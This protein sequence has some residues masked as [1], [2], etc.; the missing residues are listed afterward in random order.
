MSGINRS[1]CLHNKPSQS[2]AQREKKDQHGQHTPREG[3]TGHNRRGFGILGHHAA[4]SASPRRGVEQ[5]SDDE[6]GEESHV[7]KVASAARQFKPCAKRWLVE[8]S[9]PAS[10]PVSSGG[11]GRGLPG[12][13]SFRFTVFSRRKAGPKKAVRSFRT[14]VHSLR[15]AAQD[16]PNT[17][18]WARSDFLTFPLSQEIP[19]P[20]LRGQFCYED[21]FRQSRGD[22]AQLVGR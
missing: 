14:P 18:N 7:G 9:V 10:R 17:E 1:D 12:V 16:R 13:F 20:I 6:G 22:P 4:S 21:F 5:E 19:A 3:H 15:K 8:A 11:R 2:A